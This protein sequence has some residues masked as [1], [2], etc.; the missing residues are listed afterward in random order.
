MGLIEIIEIMK[1]DFLR[2]AV[3][4]LIFFLVCAYINSF[5]RYALPFSTTPASGETDIPAV[6]RWATAL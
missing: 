1:I 4:K 5:F 2:Y 6:T 3:K